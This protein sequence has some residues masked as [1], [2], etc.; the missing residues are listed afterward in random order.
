VATDPNQNDLQLISDNVLNNNYRFDDLPDQVKNKLSTY[1]QSQAPAD[2]TTGQPDLNALAQQRNASRDS[3]GGM[4]F[5][6]K[7][8][9]ALGSGLY[10]LYSQT[11]SPAVSTLAL[12]AHRAI[13]GKEAGDQYAGDFW[14]VQDAKDLW[15]D[16]HKVSPGQAIW[17]LGLN[18]KELSD[19]GISPNQ[20]AMDKDLMAKGGFKAG[21][22]PAYMGYYGTGAAK[23]VTGT[24]DFALS[25]YAD[26]AVIGLKTA[27]AATKGL[28]GGE[29]T[30]QLEATKAA[31]GKPEEAFNRL[32]ETSSFQKTVNM[33]DDI[34]VNNPDNGALI[35]RDRLKVVDQSANGDVFARIAMQAKSKDEIQDLLRITMGDTA[36]QLSLQMKS[37]VLDA[38]IKTITAKQ[39]ALQT[40][41]ASWSPAR[42]ASPLGV[43][44]GTVMEQ[45][46]KTIARMEADHGILSDKMTLF[47]SID[48]L[49]YNEILTPAALSAKDTDL[50]SGAVSAKPMTGQG[51]V[52]GIVNTA[53]NAGGILPIKLVRTYNDIKPSYFIDLHAEDSYKELNAALMEHKGLPRDTREAMVSDY[54]KATPNERQRV[55]VD[56]ENNVV[57]KMVDDYNIRNPEAQIDRA[58]AGDLYDDF[59]TRRQGTQ[60]AASK[61][62]TYG[63]ARIEDPTAPGLSVRIAEIDAGGGRIIPTPIFDTQ[64]ANNHILLDFATMEKAIESQGQNFQKLRDFGG[65]TWH[66]T[67]AMADSLGTIWKFAQLA[68]L[69]YSPRAMAD[70]FLGQLARFGGVMMGARVGK[71]TTTFATDMV[72]GKFMKDSVETARANMQLIDVQLGDLSRLQAS[73]KAEML[74]I[75]AGKHTVSVQREKALNDTYK[76]ATSKIEDLRLQHHDYSQRAALGSQMRDEKIGRQ[77]FAGPY[78]GKEG[79]LFQ[80]LS[81]GQRN[82]ANSMGNAGDWYLRRMRRGNWVDVS[83]GSVGA[84]KHMEAWHRVVND[85]IG[86]SAIGRL[87]LEG[88]SENEILNWMRTTPEG[89]A[90][91]K[92]IGLK[93]QPDIELARG[94]IKYVDDIMPIA[95]PGMRE[96]RLAAAKGEL[97]TDMLEKLPARNRPDVNAEMFSNIEGRGAVSQ[98]MDNTIESFYKW[99]NQMPATHLLRNPLFGQQYRA[100]LA[101]AMKRL[102]I[103]GTTHVDEA[104][105]KILESNARRAA[106]RDVK[107]FTFNMDHETKLAYSMRHFGAFFGAQ[108][109]S[110]NRWARIISDKPQVLG[111]V[112]QIYGAPSRAG[113]VVD[114]DGNPVDASGYVTDPVT[115]EK[116]LTQYGERKILVQ[117]PEYL[118]GKAMNKALGLDE[119][120]S[121]VVPMSSLNIVL[122]HGDGYLPVGAGPFV[123]IATNHF[124][125]EDP[126]L[127]DVAR[128]FGVLPFGPQD[129]IMNFINPTTGK[130]MNESMDDRS[131]TK[132][133]TLFYAMQVEHYKYEN[134]LRKTEPQ[135]GELLDRADR[136]SWFRTAAAFGLPFSLNAQDPYQYFRD[137][138][139]RMQKLDAN[140]ADEKFYE[141]YGDSFYMFSRS[142]SQNNT[143]VKPTVEGVQMSAYYKDL[144][145]K[146]GSEYAGLIVG[147]EGNGDYSNG[148]YFY[149]KTHSAGAGSN[150]TQRVQ[151]SAQEA[152]KKGKVAEGWQQYSKAVDM[153]NAQLFKA[154]FKTYDD[155]GAEGLKNLKTAL[156]TLLTKQELDGK[157]NSFYNEAWEQEFNSM[158]KGKYD[159]NAAHLYTIATDPEL[160]AKAVNPDGSV[161]IRS[162]IYTLKAY[163]DNRRQMQKSLLIRKQAG[164]SDDINTQQNEDLKHSW[165]QFTLSLLE[166]DTRFSWV[167]SRYFGNDMGFNQDT[168]VAERGTTT[169]LGVQSGAV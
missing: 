55:L 155:P 40:S 42:Q 83:V 130:R 138:F 167:H 79:E 141:K 16:A 81:A 29:I 135:W 84:E 105:R 21:E 19:R 123:Q 120:A 38:E 23:W 46:E 54:I 47:K 11:I 8:I 56:I 117:V 132:Q 102:E 101:D 22:R 12:G 148:A 69:G 147:D 26:P 1:W 99:S 72:R 156:V 96:A 41:F 119:D 114:T 154:G 90:Y 113:M 28:K 125:K 126:N 166:A 35:M 63:S 136:W 108:Q 76:D 82:F 118:G 57:H 162:D 61:R 89:K 150:Q 116:K 48:N 98:F 164:G 107:S 158:D 43:R 6:L 142:M 20:M 109:E 80:D 15:S 24:T 10:W 67:E 111:R 95:G 5:F 129:S 112:S 73:T 4:P 121:F 131:A 52:K 3:V 106:L 70:D 17:Q 49:H 110:W 93:H 53:Y 59:V 64:L 144:I 65:K 39:T 146:V 7:P 78:A 115:G 18:N 75:Q 149:Q 44:V 97:T 50:V 134:G 139:S 87:A 86:Q 151:L 13:Y 143:G 145:D 159:R 137:E 36:G 88:K 94:V 14:G 45:Q 27:G 133:R 91:R 127:A 77:V 74:R 60:A 168:A 62:Q 25:W 169:Q 34:R 153:I 140:S 37:A 152:W 122:N 92:D 51:A 124:A 85:Q 160:W 104:T 33:L 68:R 100:N 2:K 30:A 58:I 66:Q 103:Q 31:T 157:K 163:L 165:N 32:A 9:E 128:R 71:G 161:G